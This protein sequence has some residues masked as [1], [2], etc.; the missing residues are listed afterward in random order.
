[1]TRRS[2]SKLNLRAEAFAALVL[3]FKAMAAGS[4][5]PL[6]EKPWTGWKLG[7]FQEYF[8]YTGVSESSFYI[9]PGGT[10][11]LFDR[12]DYLAITRL[13]RAVPVKLGPER[14][15]GD[16]IARYVW[17]VNP[18][19]A[20]VGY[21]D[22]SHWYS[23]HAGQSRKREGRDMSSDYYGNVLEFSSCGRV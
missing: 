21:M 7:E 18:D 20:D 11:M 19:D 8:I 6:A 12:G 16:W 4:G 10:P 17:R 5:Y 2:V 14:L 15:A 22:L 9:F 23:D 1:M 3:S 13:D